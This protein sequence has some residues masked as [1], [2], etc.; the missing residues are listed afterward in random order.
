MTST[1]VCAFCV[2]AFAHLIT[3]QPVNKIHKS[4]LASEEINE[5]FKSTVTSGEYNRIDEEFDKNVINSNEPDKMVFKT[6]VTN[7]N[8][9]FDKYA[10]LLKAIEPDK[11]NS[12]FET[13]LTSGNIVPKQIT[14]NKPYLNRQR[15]RRHIFTSKCPSNKIAIGSEC[16]TCKEIN[17]EDDRCT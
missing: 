17:Y 9:E 16:F 8:E 11:I 10:I 2:A 14:V 5:E 6:D 15:V 7:Q 3:S 4:K 12:D 13:V 1:L